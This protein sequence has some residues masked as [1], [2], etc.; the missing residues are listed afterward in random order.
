MGPP[1]QLTPKAASSPNHDR[2]AE[3][4]YTGAVENEIEPACVA[5]DQAL[6]HFDDRTKE[7][8]NAAHDQRPGPRNERGHARGYRPESKQMG[9]FVY[10]RR[11]SFNGGS[12]TQH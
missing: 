10:S 4:R 2:E 5:T 1:L 6:Y 8:S 3:N 7:Q 12:R 9:Q 11:R